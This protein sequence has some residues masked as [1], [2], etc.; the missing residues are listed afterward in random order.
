MKKQGIELEYF[1]IQGKGFIGYMRNLPELKRI[2]KSFNPD[3]VHAHYSLSAATASSVCRK[4]MVVS[5]MGSDTVVS[6][7]MK[8]IIRLLSAL[9]WKAILVKSEGMRRNI[10]ICSSIVIPN[11]VDTEY[12]YQ[13]EQTECKKKIGYDI[14][15]KQV[16]WLANPMRYSKNIELANQALQKVQD[17]D[18]EFKVVYDIPHDK[19]LYH[20]NAA[21]VILLTSRWE[22]S[23]NVIKEA[24]ACNCPIVSTDVGDVRQVIGETEGCFITTFEPDD[25]AR[26]IQLA[27]NFAEQRGR[28]RGR[29]RILEL[30]LDS[31]T[32]ARKLIS[33]YRQVVA[34]Q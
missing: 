2:I 11:G 24:M 14:Q 26:K 7:P 9:K 17:T 12:W 31:E 1:A 27:L 33:I 16:I 34:E 20:L 32:I 6:L 29:E 18:I 15:R 30:G 25:V 13:L 3:L 28:T 8:L 19:V 4:A 10:G 5:L 23:P 21:D 22:G